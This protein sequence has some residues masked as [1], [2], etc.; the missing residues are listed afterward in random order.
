[1][2]S[3]SELTRKEKGIELL[4]WISVLPAAVLG[5]YA[6]YVIG[7]ILVWLALTVGLVNPPSD[8]SGFNRSLRYLIWMFPKGVACVIAGAKTAPRCRLATASVVAVLWMLWTD[9]IHRFAG[10]TVVATAVAAGCG[11]AFIFV[12]EKSKTRPK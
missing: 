4:R 9:M 2:K 5:D 6:G 1:M 8:D 7:G 12:S 3:F 10:P 11:V